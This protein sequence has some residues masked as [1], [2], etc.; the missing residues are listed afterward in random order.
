MATTREV[1]LPFREAHSRLDAERRRLTY[2]EQE[3]LRHG[4][5]LIARSVGHAAKAFNYIFVASLLEELFRV[6]G[7]AIVRDVCTISPPLRQL[8]P[9]ARALLDSGLWRETGGTRVA[10][11]ISRAEAIRS[12]RGHET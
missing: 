1:E 9:E 12:I 4:R 6:L 11:W 7:H 3:G 10:R 5:D 8:P 2:L